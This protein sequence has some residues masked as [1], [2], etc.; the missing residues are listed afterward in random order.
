ML[1]ALKV[2]KFGRLTTCAADFGEPSDCILNPCRVAVHQVSDH[3]TYRK[4]KFMR[5][6]VR[7]A[8]LLLLTSS[9]L[10]PWQSASDGRTFSI[11]G[12]SDYAKIL[13]V[14]GKSYVEVQDMARLTR[15]SISFSTNQV[16]LSLPAQPVSGAA[17]PAAQGFSKEFRETGIELMSSLREWRITIVNSIQNNSPV[18][19]EWVS[20]LQRRA[21]KDLALVGSA[22]S[23][24]DDRSGYS[25][26]AA[27]F[28]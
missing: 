14:N 22:R 23:T 26:L 18:S 6:V 25:L 19:E 4:R 1:R 3:L 9:I 11:A 10:T 20:E 5:N 7:L 17:L 21:Q 24:Q 16:L 28:S 8:L 13:E 27:E 15:G 12:Q 2:G